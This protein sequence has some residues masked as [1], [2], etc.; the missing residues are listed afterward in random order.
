MGVRLKRTMKA[1]KA[2]VQNLTEV[3]LLDA[4]K[5]WGRNR[6]AVA[7][8]IGSAALVLLLVGVG[9]LGAV[10]L[11]SVAGD[12]AREASVLHL[13]IADTATSAQV[14]SL[15]TQLAQDP[16]VVSVVYVSSADALQR[17][18][19][20]PGMDELLNDIDGNPIPAGFDVRVRSL[21]DVDALVRRLSGDPALDPDQPTSYDAASY[22][23]L[24]DAI[25]IAAL[26]ILAVVAAVGLIAAGVIANAIRAA[27]VAREDEVR[28]MGLVGAP[29]WLVRAPF[30]F[31]GAVTGAGGA[32]I[33]AGLLLL[34][35]YLLGQTTGASTLSVVLPG[36]TP[37]VAVLVAGSLVPSGAA[38]GS[39][40]ALIATRRLVS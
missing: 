34:I 9:E 8:A 7:P 4:L 14:D 26:V 18:R 31:E 28:T 39:G 36:V 15:R 32:F 17:A 37:A 38:L 12:Q 6:A 13:Y 29:R 24:Q 11:E 10:V 1:A 23:G 25:R 2:L 20:R 33:A 35:C 16:S 21:P 19:E 40:S 5:S 22:Q 30:V 3:L 27:A